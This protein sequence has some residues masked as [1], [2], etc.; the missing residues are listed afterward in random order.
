MERRHALKLLAGAAALPMLSRK[1]LALFRQVHDQ[2]PASAALKT[3][4]AH[5]NATVTTIAELIIPRTDTPGAKAV[6]VNEFIDLIVTDWY[7]SQERTR[8]LD[9]LADVDARSRRQFS[10][11][12]VGCEGTQQAEI[13]GAL[14][15]EMVKARK[16][17]K[18]N[19]HRKKNDRPDADNF[20]FMMKNL[21]L[22]GYYT[23][24]AGNQEELHAEIIPSR[25]EACAPLEEESQGQN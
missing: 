10:K 16:A 14:D 2:L 13:L 12:F 15:A 18:A 6:R 19:A 21:T 4:N 25:H 24:E 9:G 23:S 1:A 3:F 5:Q 8:F 17:G 7:D 22:I 11:D 20:F